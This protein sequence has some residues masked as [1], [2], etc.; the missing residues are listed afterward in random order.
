MKSN[1]IQ[2]SELYEWTI[3]NLHKL[4]DAEQAITLENLKH[5][6]WV[7]DMLDT[8]SPQERHIF[9]HT[10]ASQLVKD[11]IPFCLMSLTCILYNLKLRGV[12]ISDL[13]TLINTSE[14]I[15][16]NIENECFR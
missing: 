9:R 3:N 11:T 1:Y 5:L 7:P 4:P 13:E 15:R 16:Y 6:K 8:L 10:L 2:P 12:D 14:K